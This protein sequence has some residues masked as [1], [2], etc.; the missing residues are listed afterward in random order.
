MEQNRA[1]EEGRQCDVASED[2]AD[3]CAQ[4]DLHRT[5]IRFRVQQQTHCSGQA[6]PGCSLR[7]IF[8][9]IRLGNP[10]TQPREMARS[11]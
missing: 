11:G 2:H 9:A 6:T 1:S 8:R 5:T 7:I 4:S 10:F 3:C